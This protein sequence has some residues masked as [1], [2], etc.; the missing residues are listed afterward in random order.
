MPVS[1]LTIA[2]D[3]DGVTCTEICEDWY[4]H[5][6]LFYKLKP[7]WEYLN[8]RPAQEPLPYDLTTMFVIP[9]TRTGYEFWDDLNLYDDKEP[10]ADSVRVLKQLHQEGNDIAIVSRIMG[11]HEQSKRLWSQHHFPFAKFV[12]T[13]HKE[14]ISCDYI[15]DDSIV[16]L[17]KMPMSTCCIKFRLDYAFPV[18]A[19][20]TMKVVYN[21]DEAYKFIQ[22]RGGDWN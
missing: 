1:N 19:Q 8:Y 17:N 15:I 5:L 20:R 16:V 14:L 7:R 12:A 13:E 21:F 6:K 2:V 4:N 9:K 22:T 3:I 18:E 10:R 11:C